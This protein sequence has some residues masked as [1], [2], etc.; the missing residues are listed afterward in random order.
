MAILESTALSPQSSYGCC[1]NCD[2]SLDGRNVITCPECGGHPINRRGSFLLTTIMTVAMEAPVITAK[3]WVLSS[4]A[5]A[6]DL[7]RPCLQN[8]KDCDRHFALVRHAPV[9]TLESFPRDFECM[10][11]E[12]ETIDG[13]LSQF[14]P[15]TQTFSTSAFRVAPILMPFLCGHEPGALKHEISRV[16]HQAQLH[17]VS[18]VLPSPLNPP[19]YWL[20]AWAGSSPDLQDSLNLVIVKLA[21]S[22]PLPPP[23][24]QNPIHSNAARSY[25]D[26]I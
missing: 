19:A 15:S 7:P 21:P 2:V 26:G 1:G 11:R 6:V 17:R 5:L 8:T 16:T 10:I 13:I 9:R 12:G 4:D 3:A 22:P 23:P 20:L 14:R 25:V 18:T 24:I